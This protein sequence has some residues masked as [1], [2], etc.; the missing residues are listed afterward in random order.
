MARR[1]SDEEYEKHRANIRSFISSNEIGKALSYLLGLADDLF[2]E[3]SGN[4]AS[5]I[6]MELNDTQDF[7]NK[8]MISFAERQECKKRI[9][10]RCF[11][12]LRGMRGLSRVGHKVSQIQSTLGH[13]QTE[14]VNIRLTTLSG[15][16][17]KSRFERMKNTIGPLLKKFIGYVPSTILGGYILL[18]IILLK[19][20]IKNCQSFEIN[21]MEESDE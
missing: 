16:D 21:Y 1:M 4:L 13:L 14:K 3:K 19:R 6:I 20:V 17:L 2:D 11:E 18:Q 10:G 5:I 9:C 15:S 12:I 8:G 7:F